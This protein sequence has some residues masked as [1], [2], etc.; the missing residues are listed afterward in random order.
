M[1]AFDRTRPSP[2]CSRSSRS[3]LSTLL[4]STLHNHSR[5]LRLFSSF[6][7]FMI[8]LLDDLNPVTL[9]TVSG[10]TRVQRAACSAQRRIAE[11]VRFSLD[12]LKHFLSFEAH[13]KLFLRNLLHF[14]R[15]IFS[16]ILPYTKLHLKNFTNFFYS[17][18]FYW[19]NY[20]P[21][22]LEI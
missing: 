10:C 11:R 4:H 22:K 6:L 16:R 14:Y 2:T 19:L 8:L 20:C 21:E 9:L 17:Q 18:D 13:K 7:L 12:F 15:Q 3:L 5:S 1:S